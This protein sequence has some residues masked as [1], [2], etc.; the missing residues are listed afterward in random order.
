MCIY[1]SLPYFVIFDVVKTDFTN[2]FPARTAYAVK[3]LPKVCVIFDSTF[4]VPLLLWHKW[5]LGFNKPAAA[6][7][8][9][10]GDLFGAIYQGLQ[11]F[12][13]LNRLVQNVV[14][15]FWPDYVF[16]VPTL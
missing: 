16:R 2:R 4:V 5:Y 14:N 9:F 7:C 1:G 13:R 8:K 3:D 12:G 11:F 6:I 10:I 15:F